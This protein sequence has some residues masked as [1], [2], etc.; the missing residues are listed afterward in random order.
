MRDWT[1]LTD[2]RGHINELFSSRITKLT[3]WIWKHSVTLALVAVDACTRMGAECT[4]YDGTQNALASKTGI[5]VISYIRE[6]AIST[7]SK[8]IA[9]STP[10]DCYA[11]R[12]AFE[13]VRVEKISVCLFTKIAYPISGTVQ[14]VCRCIRAGSALSARWGIFK[15]PI[16]F[17]TLRADTEGWTNQA[18]HNSRWA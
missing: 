16:S 2:L 1:N 9:D 6:S 4:S 13:I 11:T 10:I 7:F 3:L 18:I 12:V 8:W 14:T 5:T 17:I 15:V